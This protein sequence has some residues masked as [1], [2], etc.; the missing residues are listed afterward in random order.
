[1]LSSFVFSVA[2]AVVVE[3]RCSAVYFLFVLPAFVSH[4]FI[5]VSGAQQ[6]F[7]NCFILLSL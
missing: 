4:F 7:L 5:D 1:M 2:V 3:A 6:I